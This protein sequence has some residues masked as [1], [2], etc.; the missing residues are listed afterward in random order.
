MSHLSTVSRAPAKDGLMH[1]DTSPVFIVGHARS[2]TSL[3]TNLIREHLEIAFG[4]ESQ[5]IVRLSRGVTAFGDLT[6][7]ANRRKFVESVAS[8]RF[9]ARSR[10]NY[11]FSF[12]IDAAV[13][14]SVAGTYRSVLDTIFGQLAA[15]MG[16]ARWGDKTPEYAHHLPLLHD[17]Y[18]EASFIHVIRDGR[19]VALSTFETQFGAKNAWAAAHEWV[20]CLEDVQQFR[21]AYPAARILDVRYE[22]LLRQPDDVFQS[23]I[24]FLQI[25]GPEGFASR[26]SAAVR[27]SLRVGNSEKWRARFSSGEH[28][29]FE[30]VA[31]RWLDRYGYERIAPKA[32]PAGRLGSWYWMA[33]NL[34][35]RA[36]AGGY[37]RDSLYRLGLRLGAIGRPLR[38]FGN[39]R[40]R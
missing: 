27:G 8:E 35:R 18:P 29:R 1:R 15:Q 6:V 40:S 5:F 25:A 24:A 13:R 3:L 31:G 36:S 19:D 16:Y 39:P 30:S 14:Q 2:G 11:G 37:W 26:I 23:L 33:D 17:L 32:T 20:R 9:F 7:E 22:D 12:D 38:A 28:D 21:Q 10:K 34:A 4:T